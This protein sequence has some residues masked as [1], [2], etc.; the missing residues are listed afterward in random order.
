MPSPWPPRPCPRRSAEGIIEARLPVH[1]W[2][3]R[4]LVIAAVD[5]VTGAFV[6][7]DKGSGVGLVDAVAASCA[8]PGVW[9]PVTIGDRR[10]IDGGVRSTVNADLAEGA[11]R[12]VVVAP[13]AMGLNGSIHHEIEAL[14]AE[15]AD[16]A[17]V[18]ADEASVAAF[19]ANPLHPATREPSARAG[20]AQGP[21][22]ADAVA[23]VWG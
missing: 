14:E 16:V 5:A 7:F 8:V 19:G 11:D 13:I 2:P 15:G 12:V 10:Y 3:E 21:S 4:P 6:P 20:R 9:P 18:V 22:V 17:V 23:E 1:E